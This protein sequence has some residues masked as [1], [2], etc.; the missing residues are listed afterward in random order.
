MKRV[1]S[2]DGGGIRGL[3]PAVICSRI[4]ELTR[5]S[6]RG[7]FDLI[8]GTSTGGI[9]ALGLA[10]KGLV[11]TM[12]E[13][14]DFYKNSGP[15]IFAEP[16]SVFGQIIRPKFKNE[17]LLKA[18]TGVFGNA[19]LSDT[20]PDVVIT[21]YDTK[22]RVPVY[23]RTVD[24]KDDSSK[25]FKVVDVAMATS[26]AP[27][28][29]PPYSLG[30][31]LLIDGGVV[32]NNPS[33]LAF[34]HAKNQWPNE[35]VLMVSLGTGT[36][37]RPLASLSGLG[38][39]LG[40]WATSIVDCVFDGTSKATEDF[41]RYAHLDNHLRIQPNLDRE[42]E[43]LD[44]VSKKALLGLE[45]VALN[46]VRARES[47]ILRMF[48]RLKVAGQPISAEITYPSNRQFVKPGPITIRG[49]VRN[50]NSE[51]LYAFTGKPGRYWPS[52]RILPSGDNWSTDLHFGTT[53]KDAHITVGVVDE[54]IAEYLE[55]YRSIA[56][57][58]GF[59]GIV[60]SC[61]QTILREIDVS[62]DYR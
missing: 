38:W 41:F 44:F 55:M 25:N 57:T 3:I 51:I 35:D 43:G 13:L 33:C 31:Q 8:A 46:E 19:K 15:E 28:Y 9:V 56:F 32:A 34:A 29:L 14:V 5:R 21:S 50:Y 42:I 26:A 54:T 59:C 24:A 52:Q 62:L 36:S 47:E 11:D 10:S 20:H 60:L 39:G 1:L 18:L 27:V 12:Q 2:I 40:Q 6:M 37:A 16:R 53:E 7:D 17:E 4:E 49:T 23:F 22:T 30:N 45:A 61:P 58:R 48:E